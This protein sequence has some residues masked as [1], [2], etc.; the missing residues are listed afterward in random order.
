MGIIL[1]ELK[2]PLGAQRK[3]KMGNGNPKFPEPSFKAQWGPSK[4]WPS[5]NKEL[6]ELRKKFP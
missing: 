4:I 6:Q 1:K 3:L 5:N 2:M